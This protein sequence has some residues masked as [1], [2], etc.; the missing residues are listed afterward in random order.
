[1]DP[2]NLSTPELID[3]IVSHH[4]AF[5]RGA[6][7]FLVPLAAK[8]ANVHGDHDPRLRELQQEFVELRASLDLHLDDEE[9]TLFREA[10]A[11]RPDPRQLDGM[12]EEHEQMSRALGR[13]RALCDG[14]APPAWACSS[15]R[16]LLAEL[17]ALED[18]L[19]AHMRIEDEVLAPRFAAQP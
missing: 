14:Y 12:R 4:H 6:L 3:Y 15:Y 11:A 5:L 7:P 18:D 19:V 1:M 9:E 2:A 16:R 17:K 10:V 13:I 8:V